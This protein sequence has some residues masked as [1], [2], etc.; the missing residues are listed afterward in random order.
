MIINEKIKRIEIL[1][2]I[3]SINLDD[4]YKKKQLRKLY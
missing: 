4:N 2:H 3:K 1:K